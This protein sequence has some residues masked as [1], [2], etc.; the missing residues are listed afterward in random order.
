MGGGRGCAVPIWHTSGMAKTFQGWRGAE[1]AAAE[2]MRDELGIRDARVTSGGSDAGIDVASKTAL[3]QVKME[4]RPIGRPALQRL[5]GAAHG[6]QKELLFFSVSGF[7]PQAV[8]YGDQVGVKMFVLDPAGSL[9]PVGHGARAVLPSRGITAPRLP[10]KSSVRAADPGKDAGPL[11]ARDSFGCGAIVF[12]VMAI[13]AWNASPWSNGAW[14]AAFLGIYGAIAIAFSWSEHSVVAKRLGSGAQRPDVSGQVGLGLFIVGPLAAVLLMVAVRTLLQAPH[15][16][17]VLAAC[18]LAA[19]AAGLVAG[20]LWA[21]R[22]NATHA[23]SELA[24]PL[25]TTFGCLLPVASILA[26]VGLAGVVAQ[27][28]WA[29]LPLLGGIGLASWAVRKIRRRAEKRPT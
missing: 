25:G 19:I 5:V 7:S 22:V 4:G 29:A 2:W 18:G 12:V 8:A 26:V 24:D 16:L 20:S 15:P 9:T 23:A 27:D 21:I 1:A 17:E 3:A 13:V 6:T 28:G 14:W 11:T 10:S